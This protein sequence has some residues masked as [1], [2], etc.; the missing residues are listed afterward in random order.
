VRTQDDKYTESAVARQRA[1]IAE[2]SAIRRNWSTLCLCLFLSRFDLTRPSLLSLSF[3]FCWIACET[4]VSI[5]GVQ[6]KDV[7]MGIL[8]RRRRRM[9]RCW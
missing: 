4:F 8:Q 7:G 1:L 9:G 3:F 6:Q 5:T 2:V